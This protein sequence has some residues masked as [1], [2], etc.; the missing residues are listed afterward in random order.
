MKTCLSAQRTLTKPITM[1]LISL[2]LL[3]IL[4]LRK[5]LFLEI[6][7]NAD[8]NVALVI[9][10]PHLNHIISTVD[11]VEKTSVNNTHYI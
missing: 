11:C 5:H 10:Y 6:H 4:K 1:K 7:N 3:W 2:L 9:N 8:V